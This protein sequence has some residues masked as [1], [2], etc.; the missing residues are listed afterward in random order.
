MSMSLNIGLLAYT[1]LP[2]TVFVRVPNERGRWMLVDRAVVEVDCAH[3]KA[4]A[5][6]PC[7]R[8]WPEVN[9]PDG[10]APRTIAYH[11]ATHTHRKRDWDR[12]RGFRKAGIGAEPYKLRVGLA[13]LEAAQADIE[14]DFG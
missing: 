6:E 8:K 3:C 12:K 9:S 4:I 14:E 2:G 1:A 5:G 11:V 7:R 10:I 13:D